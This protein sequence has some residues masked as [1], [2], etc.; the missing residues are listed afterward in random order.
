[1]GVEM[2]EEETHDDDLPPALE[3][4]EVDAEESKMEEVD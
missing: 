1:M 4:E 2:E 3:G